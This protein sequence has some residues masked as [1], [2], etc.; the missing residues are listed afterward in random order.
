MQIQAI[1]GAT[2]RQTAAPET[3]DDAA[4]RPYSWPLFDPSGAF[5]SLAA[6]LGPVRWLAHL[7]WPLA[8][9]ATIGAMFNWTA[10]SLHV[11]RVI[12]EISFWQSLVISMLTANLASR[13]AIGIVMARYGAISH[14]FGVTLRFGI[15]PKFYIDRKPIRK[16][17]LRE[18]RI[19]YSTTLMAKLALYALGTFA[20]IML[21]RTGSGAADVALA[22]GLVGLGSFLFAANPLLP[23]DGCNWLSARLGRPKLWKESFQLSA[24]ILRRQPLPEGLDWREASAMVLYAVA[25][26]VFTA[27]LF[28]AIVIGAMFAL[29]AQFGGNGVVMFCVLLAISTHFVISVR[30]RRPSTKSKQRQGKA[31]PRR[32]PAASPALTDALE[33]EEST[34]WMAKTPEPRRGRRAARS[35]PAQEVGARAPL[36]LTSPTV[37]GPG[38]AASPSPDREATLD[39]LLAPDTSPEEAALAEALE[40]L[41]ASEEHTAAEDGPQDAEELFDVHDLFTTDEPEAEDPL[42]LV[43]EAPQGP[44]DPPMTLRK[45]PPEA[46]ITTPPEAALQ[47]VPE[48]TFQKNAPEAT[49]P[50]RPDARAHIMALEAMLGDPKT[51]SAAPITETVRLVPP[52]SAERTVPALP[53]RTAQRRPP[54]T[55][56]AKSDDLD[57]V[58]R[59][60]AHKPRTSGPWGRRLIR[61]LMLLALIGVALLPYPFDVGGEFVIQPL[62]RAEIRTRTDGE[63]TELRVDEGDWVAAGQIMAVLSNW[64]EKRDIAVREADLARLQAE[65]QSL[66]EGPTPAE[67]AVAEQRLATAQIGLEIASSNFERVERLFEAGTITRI[68]YDDTRGMFR[69]AEAGVAEAEANLDL[70]R[71]EATPAE[72]AAAR[73]E[74]AKHEEDLAFARLKLEQTYV[75]AVVEGQV[76]SSMALVPIGT[77]LPEG[78]LFAELEDNRTVIAEIEVP[79][80]SIDEVG[81]GAEVELRAW[82]DTSES[83]FGTVKRLA[84]RAEEREFGRIVRVLVEVPNPDGRL[85]ANMTGQGKIEAGI[86]PVWQVFTRIIVRFFE[87]ELWS[88]LP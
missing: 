17:E 1:P 26:I 10:F 73:A 7:I 60:G 71:A 3:E 45:V 63:I 57:Q 74:I 81:I 47:N 40:G 16:L 69:L 44:Q 15:L 38:A 2:R 61:L 72:I 36:R 5:Q 55:R 85:A 54:A 29:E 27:F 32:R 22:L 79:E 53:A 77:F 82:S 87:V 35:E 28:Y 70:V 62:D 30:M 51:V 4:A 68:Q 37:R 67:I 13:V 52:G 84:P 48:A 50:S 14:V 88:W 75:Q 21:R 8:I 9:V 56:P 76:V 46:E 11:S 19:C 78:G 66:I 65:L 49:P 25:A 83:F 33:S 86:R 39:D 58:L 12:Y 80:T 41:L 6:T 42:E 31:R 34:D 18:R 24:L 59:M 43:A 20:W 64:D 23:L